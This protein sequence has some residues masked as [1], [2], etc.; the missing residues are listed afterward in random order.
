MERRSLQILELYHDQLIFSLTLAKKKAYIQPNLNQFLVKQIPA[1]FS[2]TS[3]IITHLNITASSFLA[4]N[5]NKKSTRPTHIRCQLPFTWSYQ[6]KASNYRRSYNLKASIK[7][8]QIIIQIKHFNHIIISLYLS[9]L[10]SLNRV[11][12]K[13]AQ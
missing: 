8:L 10:E 7:L 5:L 6:I 11:L 9:K 3:D 1:N 4:Q 13:T 12:S 2:N